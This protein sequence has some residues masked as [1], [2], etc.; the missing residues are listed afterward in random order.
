MALRSPFS[1]KIGIVSKNHCYDP[2]LHKPYLAVSVLGKKRQ[3][4]R[5][6]VFCENRFCKKNVTSIPASLI[7]PEARHPVKAGE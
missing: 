6:I 3:F 4:L 1:R 7:F 2:I 5:Q